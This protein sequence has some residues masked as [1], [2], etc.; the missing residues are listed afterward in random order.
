MKIIPA[1]DIMDGKC[2]RLLQGDFQRKNIYDDDISHTL[3]RFKNSGADFLHIIDL[4]AADNP[5][6]SQ[7]SFICPKIN[8]SF[9]I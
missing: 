1:I 9:F 7:K 3:L 4:S 5:S 6:N 2:V 8:C